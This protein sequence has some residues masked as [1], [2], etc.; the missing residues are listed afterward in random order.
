[1]QAPKSSL[2]LAAEMQSEELVSIFLEHGVDINL[3]DESGHIPLRT[4]LLSAKQMSSKF[5]VFLLMHGADLEAL[6][7]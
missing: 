3:R 7:C 6:F 5:L 2:H 1:M 4:A